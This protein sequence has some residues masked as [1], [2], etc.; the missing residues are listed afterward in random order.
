MSEPLP[1]FR[2]SG[3][4]RDIGNRALIT[5]ERPE[6]LNQGTI[7]LPIRSEGD[8]PVPVRR[9]GFEREIRV[10]R[11]TVI[12][13]KAPS[14]IHCSIINSDGERVVD[15][16]PIPAPELQEELQDGDRVIRL[17]SRNPLYQVPFPV[18]L[19]GQVTILD[20]IDPE[21]GTGSLATIVEVVG[22]DFGILPAFT[23]R[24]S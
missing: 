6:G 1:V 11:D 12:M 19:A 15:R 7:H 24:A 23:L 13:W 8:P 20:E 18:G 2:I 9:I 3:I 16:H 22:E 21:F 4:S 14:F 17:G 5:P 10:N